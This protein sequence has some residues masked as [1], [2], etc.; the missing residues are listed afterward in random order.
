MKNSIHNASQYD[1]NPTVLIVGGSLVGLS[2]ALFLSWRGIRSLVVERHPALARLPRARAFN[3]RTMELFRAVG[4]EATIRAAH[5]PI[6]DNNLSLRVESLAGR[7]I[8]HQFEGASEDISAASP[9]SWCHIDQDQLEPI[10]LHHA[11]KSGAEIRFNTELVSFEQDEQGVSAIIRERATGDTRRVRASYLI[12]ADGNHSMTRHA[13]DITTRGPG[14]ISHQIN[15]VFE[16]DLSA[17]LRGRRI[18]LCYIN[19]PQLPD[20]Q[21]FLMPIDGKRR[22]HFGSPLHPEKGERRED[23]TDERC[24]EQIRIAVGVPDL[25]VKILPAYP[26]DAVKVGMWE[27][28]A[29]FAEQYQRDRVFLIGDAAHAILPTGAM[30][31]STGIQDAFNLAWKMALVL[32]GQAAPSLLAS[33]TEERFPVGKLMVEQTMQRFFYRMGSGP[34]SLIDDASL[35]FGYSYRSRAI[36]AESGSVETPLTQHPAELS[37]VPGTRAPHIMLARNGEQISTIDLFGRNFVLLTGTEG[38]PWIT[39]ARQVADHKGITLDAWQIGSDALHYVEGRW[40]SAYGVSS[41]GAILVRPDGFV[42]WRAS[43]LTPQPEQVLE[44]ALVYV[45]GK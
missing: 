20:G 3:P 34:S 35:I 42:A 8:E 7:E 15:V 18:M 14:V 10:L 6:G 24:I 43:E 36:V 13:L 25:E 29:R 31:A 4:L 44:D 27:L 21:G 11:Q 28:T 16:A 17:A 39:A 12:G 45:L 9:T 5:S 2:M 23:L 26:W 41:T 32:N 19:N 33:Y 38:G 37:G 30:G 22:W 40:H 1:E